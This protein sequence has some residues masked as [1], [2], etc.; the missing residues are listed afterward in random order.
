[1]LIEVRELEKEYEAAIGCLTEEQE[2]AVRDFVTQ[3]EAMSWR[4][5]QIAC[6]IM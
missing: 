6:S 3:C 5:L 2:K 1:M 4:M